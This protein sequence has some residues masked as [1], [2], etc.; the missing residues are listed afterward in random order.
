MEETFEYPDRE[1]REFCEARLARIR[2]L[3]RRTIETLA[4]IGAHLQQVKDRLDHGQWLPWLEAHWGGSRESARRC[5]LLAR[6]LPQIPQIVQFG[7][8]TAA[9]DFVALEPWCQEKVL[10]RRAFTWSEYRAAVWDATMRRHLADEDL[11]FQNRYGDVLHAIRDDM[12]DPVLRPAA[13]ALLEEHAETFARLSDRQPEEVQAEAGA[14]WEERR[15]G[16]ERG[17]ERPSF[18][19][20]ENLNGSRCP[21]CGGRFDPT[22]PPPLRWDRLETADY[23]TFALFKRQRDPRDQAWLNA[24]ER[25]V[26]GVTKARTVDSI[27]EEL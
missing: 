5:R 14:A 22:R 18:F 24:V 9:T 4:E 23:R 12:K 3:K 25:A 10:E 17:W 6:A 15:P 26:V 19:L 11:E 13:V 16:P 8:V 1:M 2:E 20:R 21:L 7:S 27:G